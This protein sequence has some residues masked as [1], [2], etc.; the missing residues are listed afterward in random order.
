MAKQKKAQEVS[1]VRPVSYTHLALGVPVNV[2]GEALS[3][4]Q[5]AQLSNIIGAAK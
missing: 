3:L 2:R 5:F 1:A 4:A